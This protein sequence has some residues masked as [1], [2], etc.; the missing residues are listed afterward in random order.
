MEEFIGC[1]AHKKFSALMAVD[2]KGRP[3]RLGF[4]A[5]RRES[6]IP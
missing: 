2:E 6:G 4:G 5:F 3:A 1:D